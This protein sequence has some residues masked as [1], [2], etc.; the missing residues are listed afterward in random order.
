MT[1]GHANRHQ[2]GLSFEHLE[3]FQQVVE[4][5]GFAGAAARLRIAPPTVSTRVRKVEHALGVPLLWR[6]TSSRGYQL[7]EKG[8]KV[9][10]FARDVMGRLAD[11]SSDLEEMRLTRT[12]KVRIGATEEH[13]S[14]ALPSVYRMLA[15]VSCNVR[16]QTVTLG[17]QEAVDALRGGLVD[18]ALTAAKV[19]DERLA[20]IPVFQ[21]ELVLVGSASAAWMPSATE[22]GDIAGLP[23]FLL[24]QGQQSRTVMEAWA[25]GFRNIVIEGASLEFQKQG[26]IDGVALALLPASMVD[27][28]LQC[29][30]LT[31]LPQYKSR[32]R[33]FLVYNKDA[34]GVLARQKNRARGCGSR[35]S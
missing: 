20:S 10:A 23:V 28:E 26:A 6:S 16:I 12:Q 22:T 18:C 2:Y 4:N 1:T 5:G 30:I 15:A 24:G 7:T 27:A 32:R 19:G 9:A 13:A 11:L 31:E 34:C 14:V 21:D 25:V 35:E 3:T 8:E 29:G 33:V 17:E